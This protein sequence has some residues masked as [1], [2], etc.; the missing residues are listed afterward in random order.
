MFKGNCQKKN[1]TTCEKIFHR[2]SPPWR[3]IVLLIFA[4]LLYC[5]SE[6]GQF[7]CNST[8]FDVL[9]KTHGSMVSYC[10]GY[11]CCNTKNRNANLTIFSL[12]RNRK[13]VKIWKNITNH[14]DLPK[15]ITLCEEL[16]DEFS[17]SKS[18]DL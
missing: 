6:E 12:L 11:N 1:L 4:L 18:A 16:F 9:L 8:W 3:N 10:V 13:I 17:F 15:I 5:I 2:I 14:T 7:S